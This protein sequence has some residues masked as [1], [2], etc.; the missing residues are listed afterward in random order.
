[1][2]N[3]E[4]SNSLVPL[5]FAFIGGGASIVTAHIAAM[6]A[7]GGTIVGLSDVDSN[8]VAERSVEFGCPIYA[9]HKQML[10][11]TQPDVVVICTPHPS[12]VPLALDSLNMGFHILLEKPIGVDV[13][14]ADRLVV[15]AEASDR[16][17]AVCFQHRLRP[18]V[19]YVK[20]FIESGEL[21]E[22]VRILVTEPWLRTFAYYHSDGWRGKWASEGG[23]VLMNQA[24]HTLD[25]MCHFVGLPARLWGYIST[26]YQP[27]QCEDTAQAMMT[28]SNGAPGYFATS[29]A[30]AGGTRRIE[31]VG[32]RASIQLIDDHI[33]IQRF[34]PALRQFIENDPNRFSSPN[35]IT[36]T[37]HLTDDPNTKQYGSHYA[38]YL[39]LASA[40]AEGRQPACNAREGLMSLELANAIT[41]SS[42]TG[43]QVTFPLDRTAYN[44]LL[45]TLINE[46]SR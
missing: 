40:I 41:L 29:T 21:G 2:V 45:Q 24:P 19:Q 18:S 11:E 6:R 38:I 26:R 23:G 42:F 8:R 16:I 1:M 5:R 43:Q 46:Q 14:D 3:N 9:N 37:L 27:M 12:H 28:Y 36:E 20:R 44:N 32:E 4:Q 22:L 35:I 33:I 31:I 10:V 34:E 15:T 30:E 39:D 13:G 17:V 7:I 25:L